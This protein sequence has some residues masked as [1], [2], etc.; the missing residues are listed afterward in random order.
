M[1]NRRRWLKVGLLGGAALTTAGLLA[2]WQARRAGAAGILGGFV[3]QAP[4]PLPSVWST[5]AQTLV[6]A[7]APVVL[8]P[9][10]VTNADCA[11]VADGVRQAID[12]LSP[13]AQR[14][15]AELFTLLNLG[16]ARGL[17]TGV[18]VAWPDATP[19]QIEA[20]MER[21]RHSRLALFQAGYHALHDLILAAWYA[22]PSAWASIGYP[23]PPVLQPA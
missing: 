14:D 12:A 9:M 17:L 8:K 13:A 1:I 19:E 23:G 11:R 3:A 15:L 10:C 21:W 18:W 22:D 4:T 16:P 7:L 5:E 2:H 20:F 6:T